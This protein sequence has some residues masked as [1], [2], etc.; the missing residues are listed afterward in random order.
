MAQCAFIASPVKKYATV[1]E[2]IWHIGYF[3]KA[4]FDVW[5]ISPIIE[6]T[7]VQ[8]SDR[9]CASFWRYSALFAMRHTPN[10]QEITVQRHCYAHV[11]RFRILC[12]NQKSIKWP[13]AEPFEMNV[14]IE[15]RS[16]FVVDNSRQL[17]FDA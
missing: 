8:V 12:V 14:K 16:D 10:N 4:E 13:W 3:V 11:W 5:L 2:K 7:H 1:Y 6:L 9:L 15:Q 17:F